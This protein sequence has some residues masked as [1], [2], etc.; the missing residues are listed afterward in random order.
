MWKTIILQI[1]VASAL[2]TAAYAFQKLVIDQWAEE[3]KAARD[4]KYAK[5]R[6][7]GAGKKKKPAKRKARAAK[8]DLRAVP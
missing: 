4:L 1:A 5:I 3:K 7:E 2:T 6:G 8:R